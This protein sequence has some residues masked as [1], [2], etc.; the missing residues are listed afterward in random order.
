MALPKRPD[1]TVSPRARNARSQPPGKSKKGIGV[2]VARYTRLQVNNA[3]LET[4]VI[5]VFYHGDIDIVRNIVRSCAAGG[6]KVLELTNRGDHAWEV[7]SE[8]EK[9]CR[10]EVPHAILGACAGTDVGPASHCAV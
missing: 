2:T 8:L 7:F 10:H 4:G 3:I 1:Y 5:P 9:Y 6:I